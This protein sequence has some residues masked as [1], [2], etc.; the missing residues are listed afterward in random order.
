MN[1][2]VPLLKEYVHRK[3][4]KEYIDSFPEIQQQLRFRMRE[5]Q[6]RLQELDKLI[7]FSQNLRKNALDYLTHFTITINE[8]ISGTCKGIPSKWGQTL[9]EERAASKILQHHQSNL[10]KASCPL[11]KIIRVQFFNAKLYGGQQFKRL[12]AEFHELCNRTEPKITK[13]EIGTAMGIGPKS[14]AIH[15]A[16]ELAHFKLK[17]FIAPL[18]E[19]TLKRS[20]YIMKRLPDITNSILRKKL[21]PNPQFGPLAKEMFC[22]LVDKLAAKLEKMCEDEFLESKT[23]YTAIPM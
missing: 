3:A 20:V 4:W 17:E 14:G 22:E 15:A 8:L 9:R 23:I 7:E 10:I 21:N 19:Q 2:G 6:K 18:V 13:D 16:S 11:Q 12:L 1:L 5:I